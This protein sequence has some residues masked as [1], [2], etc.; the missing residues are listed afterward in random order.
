MSTNQEN[1]SSENSYFN[2][3]DKNDHINEICELAHIQ[4]LEETNHIHQEYSYT[5]ADIG[6]TVLACTGTAL[7]IV[8][9][10]TAYGELVCATSCA[11]GG[12]CVCAHH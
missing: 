3:W 2:P 12:Q 10:G 4:N 9:A 6:A 5:W 7:A 1:Q 8:T 11:I